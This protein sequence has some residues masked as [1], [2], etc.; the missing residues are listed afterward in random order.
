VTVYALAVA[1]LALSTLILAGLASF[2]WQR[3]GMPAGRAFFFV[4]ALALIWTAGGLAE[5]FTP[6]LQ[7]RIYWANLQFV[8]L[9]FLPAAQLYL[10][11]T[12]VGRPPARR[13][14]ILLCLAPVLTNLIVWTDPLH[15]WFRGQPAFDSPGSPFPVLVHDYPFWFYDI[16]LVMAYLYGLASVAV[17][18]RAFLSM[19]ALYR[20]RGLVFLLALSL[21]VLSNIAFVTGYSPI[22]HFDLTPAV[23]SLSGLIMAWNLFGFHLLDLAPL[24]RDFVFENM[25]EG[26]IVLDAQGRI[27]DFNAAAR[28]IAE[29]NAAAAGQTAQ[30]GLESLR[31]QAEEMNR[32]QLLTLDIEAGEAEDNLN[33]ELSLSPILQRG[34]VIGQI[35]SIR[36]T[37]ERRQLYNQVR[38]LAIHDSLTGAYTRRHF[39][40]LAGHKMHFLSR[41]P[42]PPTAILLLDIDNF[43][44]VNETYGHGAGDQAIVALSGKARSS[45]RPMDALC[46]WGG[47]EFV[48]WLENIDGG[49]A[50]QVAE[51]IR[52]AAAAA[53][54]A[55]SPG[56]FQITVSIGL[57]LSSDLPAGELEAEALVRLAD[58]ALHGAKT[59]GRNRLITYQELQSSA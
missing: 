22:P 46:R 37:S 39:L 14:A 30:A 42:S 4:M 32:R 55:A 23:F 33:H 53:R 44:K 21:P 16:H 54:I 26:V 34:A 6:G 13:A 18:A 48:V 36:D 49:Q 3:R 57:A 52:T 31:A 20:R 2:G 9:A 8:G 58:Q 11:L 56:V 28:R 12:Y 25:D 41:N 35:L 27:V 10:T 19:P 24:A 43:K 45:I 51:R 15:H 47:D 5:L 17:A 40:E 29:V 38:D 50:V 1:I 59:R 7:A